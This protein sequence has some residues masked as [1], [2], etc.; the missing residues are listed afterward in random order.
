MPM[1][2]ATSSSGRRAAAREMARSDGMASPRD[3]DDVKI[4]PPQYFW[5]RV[6]QAYGQDPGSYRCGVEHFGWRR[7]GRIGATKSSRTVPRSIASRTI[8]TRPP[9]ALVEIV[10]PGI[11][12]DVV[13][14]RGWRT[15]RRTARFRSRRPATR[16]RHVSDEHHA[17]AASTHRRRSATNRRPPTTSPDSGEGQVDA[18]ADCPEGD[19]AA[20][21][22]TCSCGTPSRR[23]A[24]RPRDSRSLPA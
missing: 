11:S 20:R 15:E 17:R 1:S 9:A 4:V 23:R 7:A 18:L 6:I 10:R 22:A 16:T 3:R 2:A 5:C 14:A 12:R 13:A 8:F 24:R 21:R 19:R